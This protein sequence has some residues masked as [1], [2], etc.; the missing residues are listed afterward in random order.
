MRVV[1]FILCWFL[2]LG[3]VSRS[4][5]HEVDIERIQIRELGANEYVMSFDIS[6]GQ[7]ERFG[8]PEIP[9]DCVYVG[10]ALLHEGLNRLRFKSEGG[11]LSDEDRIIL[12]WSRDGVMASA[13]WQD[14]TKARQLFDR[15]EQGV[16]IRMGDLSAGSGSRMRTM[17][18]Y[19]KLGVEHILEGYDHL[20]FVIGLSLLV[21]G[22]RRLVITVTAFTVAHSVTLGLTVMG[23]LSID[24]TLVEVLIAL[25]IAFL[26]KEILLAQ[27]GRE[28]WATRYPWIVAFSFGLIHGLGFAGALME[29]GISNESIP[30]ALMSFN[31][32]VEIGQIV[33]L[34]AWALF[35]AILLHLGLG[36]FAKLRWV[37]AY[38]IGMT[39]MFW[40]IQRLFGH[41]GLEL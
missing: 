36:N 28:T 16:I 19:T 39:A 6:Y 3:S 11:A 25:S 38:V 10:D 23:K 2:L 35:V 29:L 5:A 8:I 34:L 21:R 32:G 14:G 24:P 41:Y 7:L 9:A 15:S 31:I 30:I 13:L 18:R 17:W 26:A 4:F 33:F 27:W 20:L 22:G 40:F 12:P 1:K 37:P